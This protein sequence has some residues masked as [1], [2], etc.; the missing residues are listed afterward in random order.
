MQRVVQRSTKRH[1]EGRTE[2]EA[3]RGMHQAEA[4][5]G[6]HRGVQRHAEGHTEA[7]AHRGM[8]RGVQRHTEGHTEAEVHRGMHKGT[9]GDAQRG[10]SASALSMLRASSADPPPILVYSRVPVGASSPCWREAAAGAAAMCRACHVT[11]V[12]HMHE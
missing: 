8:H 7:E 4:H 9:Q 1:T 10:L 5:R 2:V 11:C 6:M 12:R 3:H